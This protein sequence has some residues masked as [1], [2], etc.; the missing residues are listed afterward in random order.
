[1]LTKDIRQAFLNFFE[2]R[3]H[4]VV[5]SSSLIPNDP[6][7]LLTNA[8][9][10]QFKP[11]FLGLQEPPYPR[12][13]SVQKVF[14]ASDIENVGH[15][16]RHL[17]F[18]EMLG[19]FSFGDY[20]K[21]EACAWAW[22]LVTQG[23]GIDPERLWVTA[24]ETDDEAVDIW[25]DEVGVARERIVKRGREDNFWWM[26]VAGPAGPCSEIYVDRGPKY[27]SDG[28]PAV[29][30]DRFCEIWNLVFMQNEVDDHGDV[31]GDL[32]KRNIDTGSSLERV[33]MVLQ[34]ADNVFLTDILRPLLAVAEEQTARR[35]GEDEKVDVSL[36]VMAEHGR[37]TTFLIADGVLPGNEGRGYVL[38][39]ML[40]R[41]VTHA[42][43][44]G[45]DH[46][47]MPA[48]VE[49][50][51]EL[52]GDF[53]PE[54]A[55][56]RAF[57][58]QVAES[59]EERFGGTYRQGLTLF[60]DAVKRSR[61]SGTGAAGL[62]G[63]VAFR[64]HDTHGFPLEVTLELAAEE[65]LAVD[66]ERFAQL[67]EE[68]R[69][70]GKDAA[71]KGDH[72]EGVL[73][74]VASV[75]GQTDFLGYERLAA[76]GR[77]VG[78]VRD[79]S[80]AES[81]G[82]GDQVRLVLDRTPFYAEGGGQVGDAGLI[83]TD[84]GVVRVTDTRPGPGG[85]IVHTGTVQEGEIR[86]GAEAEAQVD[87]DRRA[88]TARSHTA[89]HVLHH[90]IRTSLGEHARQ[91]GSRV[92]PG[93]LRFDFTHFEPVPRGQLEEIEYLVNRRLAEDEP[94][95]AFETTK[96]FAQ[97]QGAIALFGE[98]YGDIVRVVEVGNYSIELCGGTHVRHTGEVALVRLLHEASIG[99][100]FRRVEALT[101][102]DALKQINVER[103]LLEE[104]MEA[105]GGGDPAS[106][107]ERVRHAVER[108][109]QL[110]SE[111][112]RIRK[113]QQAGEA[114]DLVAR[115]QVV[116][117]VKLLAES[118]PGRS[119]GELRELATKLRTL[120]QN[121]PAAVVLAGAHG[122]KAVVVGALTKDLVGRGIRAADLIEPLAAAVGG[123]AG[124]KPDL[125]MGG[126]PRA[127][128]V[129]EGLRA[130]PGRL[131][132]LLDGA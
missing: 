33:A 62:P 63:D 94:V 6:T 64:L 61:D 132:E 19:N 54:L 46:P 129:D 42:R 92:E 53:Y 80:L 51:V 50:T 123:N 99:S 71:K 104:I 66:T 69:R 90:T 72:A 2:E 98:K 57:I 25:A 122:G 118:L 56:N 115:A 68:Q 55:A 93:R 24:F 111:L 52:M 105:V 48:F 88:A 3:G 47:V 97:S 102:P 108:I 43:R 27:G 32:P 31:I 21:K 101:G 13:V 124:G 85:I 58:L 95:R 117:G 67:M 37:A 126:G 74:E 87:E 41:V 28:G 1:M 120:L 77:I 60:E 82:E 116:D 78:L 127:E 86:Q 9:M 81:A 18:F 45:I 96:E 114:V 5:P 83:R 34:D 11:Y 30:E 106:T 59:E 121:E 125:A 44:L 39:R 79:G 109:K 49:K 26:H 70:R 128:G 20:F 4:K 12:A 76:E 38:R 113:A 73:G 35:Y 130:V 100:G 23:L 112:G 40:R 103:R 15:T 10:N 29:D 7:L 14:R 17:T 75:A 131:R 119:A 84:T 8:G 16:D 36:R 91:A 89:T 65:G 22:E 110:E 107:P